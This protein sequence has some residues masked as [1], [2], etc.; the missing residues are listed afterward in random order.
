MA[1]TMKEKLILYAGVFRASR[2]LKPGSVEAQKMTGTSGL[3]CLESF[4]RSGPLGLLE[5]TLLASSRWN[6]TR[7]FLIWKE[8]ATKQGHSLFQLAASMPRTNETEYGLWPTPT[9]QDNQQVKGKDQRGTTLGGAVRLWPTPAHRDHK[10]GYL[11]G[12]IRNGKVSMD[13][14]DVIVQYTDNPTRQAGHLNPEFV[15]WLMGFPI[16]W[17]ELK[18]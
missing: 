16:G 1:K 17:T 13:T 5:R 2:F 8:K 15:E 4:R 14:L 6:S 3:R 9:T 18:D 10:R 12:R 11:G 7:S